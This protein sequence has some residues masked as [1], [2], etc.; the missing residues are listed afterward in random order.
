M[1]LKVEIEGMVIGSYD[2]GKEYGEWHES[3][4]HSF[5]GI[6]LCKDDYPDLIALEEYEPGDP[7]YIV[8]AEYS[9]G[10]SFGWA[11]RGR[12]EILI[13]L[14]NLEDAKRVQKLAMLFKPEGY[15]YYFPF[16]F[17]KHTAEIYCPWLG[18]FEQL[19]EIHI[20]K[21]YIPKAY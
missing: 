5:T 17:G 16:E 10:D 14:K 7:V 13:A 18:Y 11:N 19:D 2:D 3:W 15:V 6:E 4:E 12:T 8:W 9:Q 20:D 1:K 21:A